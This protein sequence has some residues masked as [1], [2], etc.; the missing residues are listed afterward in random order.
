[1]T[2]PGFQNNSYR[3]EE[4]TWCYNGMF[5]SIEIWKFLRRMP[6]G[7]CLPCVFSITAVEHAGVEVY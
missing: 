2:L 3:E 6:Q 7:S 4:V 1:M 5:S